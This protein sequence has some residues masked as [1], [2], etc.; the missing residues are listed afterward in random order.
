MPFPVKAARRIKALPRIVK[1]GRNGKQ[2]SPVRAQK[3]RFARQ[4]RRRGTQ[5]A[6]S[7]TVKHITSTGC[8]IMC[9]WL[10]A[11]VI[12]LFYENPGMDII[13]PMLVQNIQI[14]K[15][16]I[17]YKLFLNYD[18]FFYIF[19]VSCQLLID[20]YIDF[21]YPTLFRWRD[22]KFDISTTLAR[23]CNRIK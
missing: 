4:E 3:D 2:G 20:F 22:C 12:R 16:K 9:F 13:N 7:N 19:V 14:F 8:P 11:T 6:F 15:Y 23:Y 5:T 18:V 21:K 17:L 1:S 10:P